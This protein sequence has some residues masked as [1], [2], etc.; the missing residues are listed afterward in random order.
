MMRVPCNA[1]GKGNN[2]V[3]FVKIVYSFSSLLPYLFSGTS[4]CICSRA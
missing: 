2:L 4:R 3:S 1:S